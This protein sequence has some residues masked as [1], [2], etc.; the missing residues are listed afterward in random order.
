MSSQQCFMD[1]MFCGCNLVN[2]RVKGMFREGEVLPLKAFLG[3]LQHR[4]NEATE[5]L[6]LY[7]VRQMHS[8]HRMFWEVNIPSIGILVR[9]YNLCSDALIYLYLLDKCIILTT[10]FFWYHPYCQ[11][12]FL[13]NIWDAEVFGR[14]LIQTHKLAFL[15]ILVSDPDWTLMLSYDSATNALFVPSSFP[16]STLGRRG[17]FQKCTFGSVW[18]VINFSK[19]EVGFSWG[20]PFWGYYHCP[21]GIHISIVLYRLKH[22]RQ[23]RRKAVWSVV[24]KG[25]QK[26]EQ[27]GQEQPGEKWILRF[28]LRRLTILKSDLMGNG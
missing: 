4:E 11:P 8:C 28:Q 18:E 3:L 2:Y 6:K 24:L 25:G 7:A 9:N 17:L 10:F 16:I 5:A 15:Q 23:N 20:D 21:A 12:P 14:K 13:F 22:K 26:S 27:E 1:V 19:R